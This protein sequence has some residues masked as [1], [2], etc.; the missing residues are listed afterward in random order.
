MESIYL[1]SRSRNI[2]VACILILGSFGCKKFVEIPPPQTSLTNSAVYTTSSTANA[3]QLAIY[4]QMFTANF[5]FAL[6]L[7]TGLSSDEFTNYSTA[8]AN[9]QLYVNGL[10]NT[11]TNTQAIWT[12]LYKL[13]FQSNAVI[14]GAATSGGIGTA[15]KRQLTGE[16]EFMRAY[17]YFYLT[18]LYGNVPLITSTNYENSASASRTSKSQVYQQMITDLL[19]AETLINANYV[20]AD[21][22]TIGTDRVRPN[23]FACNALLAR[24][25]LYLGQW[26][27]AT[28]QSDTVINNSTM[29]SLLS[30]LGSVFLKTNNTEAIFQVMG[31]PYNTVDGVN[32]ILT[33]TP[34]QVA[35]SPQ[36]INSFDSGDNRKKNWVSSVTVGSKV[37]YYPFK[38]KVGN[39]TSAI[40]E[41][42]MM[43][44]LA[45]QYLI[46]AEAKVQLGDNDGIN[47][48]NVIRKRAGLPNYSGGL[49]KASLLTAIAHERQVELFSEEGHRWLD[50]KRMGYIDSVMSMVTPSKS[51]KWIT[52]QQ[53]WPIPQVDRGSNANLSQN[54]G[55]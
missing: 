49:D 40:S 18:N 30:S 33:T 13:I 55:Y 47:D 38:Y 21:G 25:Y 34:G 9:I 22:V 51:G 12:N 48:L 29:Y 44:R 42:C 31:P 26:A 54:P 41:Y 19:E 23:K 7:Y 6:S 32:F 11:N 20:Q 8:S 27:D 4:Q 45:E 39:S 53:L 14:E 43:M 5:S 35:I 2:A 10:T 37:Y 16:A 3:A 52:T 15:L 24:I 17:L 28:R 50:L 1:C 46:R 36:L